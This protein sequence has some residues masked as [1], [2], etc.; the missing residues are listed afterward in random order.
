MLGVGWVIFWPSR[1][2]RVFFYSARLGSVDF[3]SG[4]VGQYNLSW[5][6]SQQMHIFSNPTTYELPKNLRT[7]VP[8]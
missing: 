3:F 2:V 5:F 7:Y 8:I 1:K 4:Q 6:L